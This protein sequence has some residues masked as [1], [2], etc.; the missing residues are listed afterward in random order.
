[1]C[2]RDREADGQGLGLGLHIARL[3]V[4][5]HGGRISLDSSAAGTTFRVVLPAP[6]QPAPGCEEDGPVATAPAPD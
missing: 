4:E 6:A 2:I 1:M 3:L 5:A